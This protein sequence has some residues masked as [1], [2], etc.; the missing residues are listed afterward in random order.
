MKGLEL[1]RLFYETYGKPMLEKEFPDKLERMAIGLVGHGS[2]CFGYDDDISKDHDYEPGFTIWLT[3]ED[4]EEFGFKLFRAYSKLPKEFMG[5]KVLNRSVSGQ[6][7]YGVHTIDEFYKN[8]LGTNYTPRTLDHWLAIPDFYLAEATNGEVFYDALGRFS[9]IR[10][11]LLNNRPEDVRLKKLASSVFNMAQSGQYNYSRCA[12][13]NELA[14]SAI[15][16]MEFAKATAETIYLLNKKY[17]PYYKWMF[18]E[19]RNLPIL[20]NLYESIEELLKSPY[21][22]T[23]N[24]EIIENIAKCVADE[25]RKEGLSEATDTYLEPY[26]YCIRNCIKDANLRNSDIMM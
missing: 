23:K 11:E 24:K 22:F 26:S 15:A 7:P 16:L 21:E 20:G 3:K 4:E 17:M 5:V 19:L 2:E 8:Y 14:A 12:S 1:S 18:K 25:I 9:Q 6:S 10:K 13:H